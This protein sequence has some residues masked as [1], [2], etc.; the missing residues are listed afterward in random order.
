MGGTDLATEFIQHV[1][2]ADDGRML[3]LFDDDAEFFFCGAA[4]RTQYRK[5]RELLAFFAW[6][7]R[8]LPKLTVAVDRMTETVRGAVVEWEASGTSARGDG[9]EALGTMVLETEH[10]RISNLRVYPD[11]AALNRALG[12][13]ADGRLRRSA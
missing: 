1:N 12:L 5:G 2:D 8:E 3:D 7:R 11:T 10:G 9:F 13:V 4:P 6:L